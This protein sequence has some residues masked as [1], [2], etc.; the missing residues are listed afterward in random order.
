MKIDEAKFVEEA[1]AEEFASKQFESTLAKLKTDP[2]K[3]LKPLCEFIEAAINSDKIASADLTVKDAEVCIKLQ[4]SIINLPL[5][6]S[7]NINKIMVGDGDVDVNVYMIIT[8]PNINKSKLRIDELD[9]SVSFLEKATGEDLERFVA[10]TKDQLE[11]IS[12]NKKA[13]TETSA[14]K[15]EAKK[16]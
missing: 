2:T 4:T 5:N 12:G 13:E 3:V 1:E 8:S 15:D 7:K 11:I 6:Y 16:A 14:S 10:W 9:D